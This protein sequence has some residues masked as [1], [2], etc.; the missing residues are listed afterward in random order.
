LLARN[1]A[2]NF[3]RDWWVVDV[4]VDRGAIRHDLFPKQSGL[5]KA[6]VKGCYRLGVVTIG[7]KDI[8]LE[9][10]V[11]MPPVTARAIYANPA[12]AA[13]ATGRLPVAFAVNARCDEV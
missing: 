10:T 9:Y 12:D 3:G 11:P 8:V 2:E 5:Q 6:R 7:P 4:A 13:W 1:P